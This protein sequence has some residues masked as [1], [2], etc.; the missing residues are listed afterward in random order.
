MCKTTESGAEAMYGPYPSAVP[1]PHIDKDGN[2]PPLDDVK[3]AKSYKDL[4]KYPDHRDLKTPDEWIPR[5]GRLVRLTG[6][7]PFNVEPPMSELRKTRFITPSS[8][9]YVRNHG[10][11]PRLTWEDHTLLLGGDVTHK[12]ELTMDELVASGPHREIPVTLVCA[13]NRR[14]E[15]NMIRQTIGFSWGPCGV[16]TNVY[17]GVL[18]RDLLIK[19]GV[20]DKHM[21]GKHVEFIGVEDLPNKVGPGPFPDEPWGKL[22][23]YGTSI[24]LSRAMNAAYDVM[25]AWEANGERLL[26]DHGYPVRLIIPGYIGGRMIKW[27]KEINVIDHETKNHYHY[28]DNRILPP[29]ITAEESLKG[30]W[31]YK[32]E[33]IFNE[34]N[35]NSAIASPLH[36]E[37]L[38]IAKNI[39]KSYN[40]SGYAYTGGGRMITRVEV[41]T[42]GGIHWELAT[43]DR[44]EM[45][46]EHDM[47]WCWVWWD[48]ELKVADLVGCKEI[49]CRAWDESNMCQPIHPTWNLMGMGNNQVFRLKV[50][51]DKKASGQ[52]VFRFEQ[53]TQPGQLAGGWMTKLA[54]KPISAGFGRLLDLAGDSVPSC[55]PSD[56]EKKD[57]SGK[58]TFT[59][60]EIRKHNTEED[61]WI[62][63]NNRVYDAT[64]YLELHPG[65]T[66]SIVINAGEDATEDFVAIHSMKATKML[67]KYYIGDLDTAAASVNKRE[68]EDLVDSKGNKLALNPRRKTQFRLQNKIVLSR[69][70]FMLDFALPTPQHVLGLPT[71]KHMFMSAVINGET[72]LRRYTPISSNYDVGCVKFVIKAYRPCERFPS[73]GKMSQYVD[74]LKIG[75][76]MD[77]RGPVG[78]FEYVAD[79]NFL[80]DGEECHGTKFNMVAGGTGITPCMQIAAE[81][82]RHPL[83]NT[84]ISL[85]FA[86]REEG[87]L[88]MRSTLDEWAANFP[89]KFKVHYILSDSW[90]TDWKYSTGFVDRKLFSDRFFSAGDGVY[91]LMCGPPVMLDRGCTPNLTALGHK[92]SSIFSF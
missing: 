9:H 86:A 33:Y 50:H 71:G 14:K 75:D 57:T 78:E 29:H 48:Y 53:P 55:P 54:G 17:K 65:G 45:P 7:H 72:V 24:P 43:L 66:D 38:P 58:K 1:V 15:Q 85:I 84:Q 63:V 37:E 13:G 87:D 46:T 49:W 77:F 12:M 52:H 90:P 59:M 82:L 8:L 51:M 88:L 81:I 79:G 18:L 27:L 44:K 69:D 74:N 19:A 31:W 73:G 89:D 61:C 5:D 64:E 60:E 91:N 22:V 70:S 39:D 47:Y 2:T 30:Q 68:E 34:L 36:D 42:D 20:S 80:L 92:K 32:P 6:R 67:E 62:I 41:S 83:D 10:A 11:C 26:P 16:S 76:V 21:R 35:I 3:G 40:V 23:K 25:V 4:D 56:A 28:H